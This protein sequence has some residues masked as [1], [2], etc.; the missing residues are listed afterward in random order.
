LLSTEYRLSDQKRTSFD[1]AFFW[2]LWIMATACGW[3]SGILFAPPVSLV[4]RGIAIGT[5]QWLVLKHRIPRAWRWIPASAVGWTIG[6]LLGLFV[7]P[8]ELDFLSATLLGAATGIAQWL[9]LRREVFWA[10]WWPVISAVAWA[11]GLILFRAPPIEGVMP[12]AMTGI[13]LEL[14]LH[15][16]RRTGPGSDTAEPVHGPHPSK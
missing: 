5:L 15:Y 9:I 14:L 7:L 2:F 10:G 16:A 6:G 1:W 8:G 3:I 13:A 4:A 11:T 12:G